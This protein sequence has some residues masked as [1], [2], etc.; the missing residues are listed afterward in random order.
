M[1]TLQ[2]NAEMEQVKGTATGIAGSGWE[3]NL[4][5][6]HLFLC[7][8][9]SFYNSSLSLSLSS[10]LSL[11]QMSSRPP[12]RNLVLSLHQRFLLVFCYHNRV[13]ALRFVAFSGAFPKTRLKDVFLFVFLFSSFIYSHSSLSL[14]LSLFC[15]LCCA[16]DH[17]SFSIF[18]SAQC[19]VVPLYSS[20]SFLF[21]LLSNFLLLFPIRISSLFSPFCV[22]FITFVTFYF[23]LGP[24]TKRLFLFFRINDEQSLSSILVLFHARFTNYFFF[25][26]RD[27]SSS[28]LQFFFSSNILIWIFSLTSLYRM[29]L[30][31]SFLYIIGRSRRDITS[32]PTRR[33]V[34]SSSSLHLLYGFVIRIYTYNNNSRKVCFN[35]I[36]NSLALPLSYHDSHS[37]ITSNWMNEPRNFETRNFV[38]VTSKSLSEISPSLSCSVFATCKQIWQRLRKERKHLSD[39]YYVY[40]TCASEKPKRTVKLEPKYSMC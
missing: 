5:R 26:R 9:F 31:M 3:G 23:Y 38:S 18:I 12:S 28:G 15:Y 4:T 7:P 32:I 19:T 13:T 25:F 14:S 39:A 36:K 8:R 10:F 22:C 34:Y 1:H 21:L 35:N 11:W 30:T 6:S 27:T 16:V 24:M 33:L 20:H 37:V 17:S 2:R 40:I 29:C